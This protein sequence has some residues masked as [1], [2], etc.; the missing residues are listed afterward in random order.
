MPLSSRQENQDFYALSTR[1]RCR[2]RMGVSMRSIPRVMLMV[3]LA[4]L[5]L[6]FLALAFAL[7]FTSLVVFPIARAAS[8]IEMRVRSVSRSHRMGIIS[9]VTMGINS[10]MHRTLRT[11]TG[12]AP[13]KIRRM[14]SG[15]SLRLAGFGARGLRQRLRL[16]LCPRRDCY[17]PDRNHRGTRRYDNPTTLIAT[18]ICHAPNHQGQQHQNLHLLH[19]FEIL[20]IPDFLNNLQVCQVQ[21]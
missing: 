18:C 7:L 8:S 15:M 20:K 21:P 16:L 2:T 9:G 10:R 5:A 4:F 17:I 19:C 3:L 13:L 1:T 6:A 11:R 12:F 14:L